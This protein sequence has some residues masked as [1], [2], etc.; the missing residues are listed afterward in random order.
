MTVAAFRH[1]FV[2]VVGLGESLE[3]LG[4]SRVKTSHLGK[5][6]RKER[7][8]PIEPPLRISLLQEPF[9]RPSGRLAPEVVETEM[10]SGKLVGG[11][12]E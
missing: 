3:G 8:D 10:T 9:T 2:H 4:N 1:Y 11:C 5:P 7:L 6:R 12:T